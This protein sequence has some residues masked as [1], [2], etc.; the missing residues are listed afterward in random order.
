VEKSERYLLPPPRMLPRGEPRP[1]IEPALRDM[2][3]FPGPEL[4]DE[5]EP[6]PSE[7][8]KNA[9][10]PDL[11]HRA[12][13]AALSD[14]RV[15]RLLDN[16]RYIAIGVSLRERRDAPKDRATTLMYVFYNYSDNVAVEV[17]LDRN[18]RQISDVAELRY[19]PAPV[20]QEL[21]QAVALARADRRL[22]ERL[23]DDLEGTAILVS[24]VDPEDPNYGH[25]QFDVRFVSPTERLPPYMA[26]VD[27]STET[28]L[29]AGGG[30]PGGL[31]G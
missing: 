19:Q 17:I 25:R 9:L 16:K 10:T 24:P 8:L 18:A 4:V 5:W 12:Q 30:Y 28:V 7:E 27:L 26:L 31:Q 14:E 2:A 6:F 20:R 3:P 22:A 11:A 13:A 15:R 23:T 29:V 21:E 1:T